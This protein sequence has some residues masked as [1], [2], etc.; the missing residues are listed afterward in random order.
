MTSLDYILLAALVVALPAE[1]LWKTVRGRARPKPPLSTKLLR[2][3]RVVAVLLAVLAFIWI[4][5]ERSAG[6]L[7]LEAPLSTGGMVGLAIAVAL[8]GLLGI[9][10]VAKRGSGE[11][12]D[13][14][15]A[16]NHMPQTPR[17]RRLFALF[18]FV[19]G[20]GWEVL[21]RG[22]LLWALAPLVGA[23][24]AVVVAAIAYALGHGSRDSKSLIG[25]V[26]AS[27]LFTIGYALT[28]SLW[29]LILLHIG[30]PLIGMA[31]MRPMRPSR[32]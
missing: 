4:R 27:F 1:A 5:E 31:A 16:A 32:T 8:L 9:G 30:L 10:T 21:Y 29:W 17:E 20:I 25:A 6:A 7:G 11:G 26:I 28:G 22:Y 13:A 14:G 19:A 12:A 24:G 18:V 15:L 3:L 23:P 2:S